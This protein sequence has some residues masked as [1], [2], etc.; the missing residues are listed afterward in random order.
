MFREEDIKRRNAIVKL[1]EDWELL[2]V[3][4]KEKLKIKYLSML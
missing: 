3:I 4:D 2:E 1:L